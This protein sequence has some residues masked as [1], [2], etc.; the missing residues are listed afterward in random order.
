MKKIWKKGRGKLG[1]LQPL[2]GR[3]TA[4]ADTPM[5]PVRCT[6][7]LEPILNGAYL[8]LEARWEFAA[9]GPGKA[10]QEIAILGAGEKGIVTFW[11]FTSDGKRSQGIVADVTD[12]HPEAVGFE[13]HMDAGLARM[14]YWPDN[15]GGFFWVVESK[16]KKGWRRF[17]EH[18]Y[19]PIG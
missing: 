2:L 7:V 18:H 10:Y 3:W 4:S 1:F 15:E 8:R 11:S 6:R 9:M 14:A 16:T 13:A 17:V 19:Q 5:G 12:L